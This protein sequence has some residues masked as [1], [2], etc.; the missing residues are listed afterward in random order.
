MAKECFGENRF[1]KVLS[2]FPLQ[3]WES[4]KHR[5]AGTSPSKTRLLNPSIAEAE[6]E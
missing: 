3:G 6:L 1:N 2:M 4:S 5:E